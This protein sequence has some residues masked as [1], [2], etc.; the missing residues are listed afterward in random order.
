MTSK[1]KADKKGRGGN[2]LSS[3]IAIERYEKH[4]AAYVSLS[5]VAKCAYVELIDLYNGS[6]NGK[7]ALSIRGLAAKLKVGKSTADRAFSELEDRGFVEALKPSCFNVK[8]G[9]RRA[10]EWRLTRCYCN[11]TGKPADKLFMQWKPSPQEQPR[12]PEI[13]NAVPP[14]VQ[15]CPATGTDGSK[16]ASGLPHLSRY[17]ASFDSKQALGCPATRPLIELYHSGSAISLAAQ[18]TT[19]S[20]VEGAANQKASDPQPPLRNQ[21]ELNNFKP[22]R[23]IL[24]IS[25]LIP[26][27][28]WPIS[29]AA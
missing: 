2:T 1:R 9:E 23:D 19:G 28:K 18:S 14:Q 20:M 5:P 22:L 3:F 12:K 6:N 21:T 7:I 25:K 10:C 27:K 26:E 17:D 4:S 8:T 24:D 11:A 16:G 15:M 29:E 13:Q